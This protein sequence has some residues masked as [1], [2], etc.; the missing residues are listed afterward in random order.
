MIITSEHEAIVSIC[1]GIIVLLFPRALS[2][3]IGICLLL[4][5]IYTLYPNLVH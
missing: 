3:I 4:G 2:V 1:L 5:G